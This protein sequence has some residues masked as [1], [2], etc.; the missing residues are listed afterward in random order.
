MLTS[1]PT[2][3]LSIMIAAL[4]LLSACGESD[5]SA[6]ADDATTKVFMHDQE[7]IYQDEIYANWPNN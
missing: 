5:S 7:V 4:F 6:A 2:I 1:K 3:L